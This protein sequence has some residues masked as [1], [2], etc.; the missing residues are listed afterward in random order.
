[1]DRE[2]AIKIVVHTLRKMIQIHDGKMHKYLEIWRQVPASW[3]SYHESAT[4]VTKSF[5]IRE[6][7]SK[8]LATFEVDG[9]LEVSIQHLIREVP[10]LMAGV[11]VWYEDSELAD[12]DSKNIVERTLNSLSVQIEKAMDV[13]FSQ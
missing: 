5:D 6:K 3:E 4:E 9:S 2:E 1:M 13:L 7:I 8:A 11:I 10:V 12:A